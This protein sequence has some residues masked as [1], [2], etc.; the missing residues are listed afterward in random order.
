M[1]E[2][3][4]PFGV[5]SGI[6]KIIASFLALFMAEPEPLGT[7]H[8]PLM[9]VAEGEV[10]DF[11]APVAFSLGEDGFGGLAI[12]GSLPASDAAR[13][14][15]FTARHIG[16]PVGFQVCGVELMAPV[17]QERIA[18]GRFLISG[19]EATETMLGFLENGCP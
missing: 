10:L 7:G 1:I 6:F 11:D 5:F 13:M 9:L 14:G 19:A 16:E 8:L 3:T 17:V 4:A 15:D 2:T 18:G 12:T